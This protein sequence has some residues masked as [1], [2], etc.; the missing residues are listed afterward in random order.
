MSALDTGVLWSIAPSLVVFLLFYTGGATALTVWCFGGRLMELHYSV[1]HKEGDLRFD[2]VRV[3]ENTGCSLC[4]HGCWWETYTQ[5][6][7]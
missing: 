1:L 2:L 5:C 3:R 6:T 7:P 4:A